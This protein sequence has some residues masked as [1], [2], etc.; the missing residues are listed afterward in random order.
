MPKDTWLAQHDITTSWPVW[1]VMDTVHAD[2]GKEFHGTML[3]KACEEYDIMLQWRPVGRPHF[4]GHI[5][6]LLGTLNH[7]MHNL[8]GS[9]FSNPRERGQYEAEQHAALTL[10]EF[11]RWLAMLIVEVYHQRVH[12]ELVVLGRN[13]P[14]LYTVNGRPLY[15]HLNGLAIVLLK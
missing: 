9:T 15:V 7:E 6:R 14:S 11:E 10:A 1:G 12:R 4:G 8:P 3:E 5:E 2:N 13:N